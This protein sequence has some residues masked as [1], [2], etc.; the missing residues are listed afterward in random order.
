MDIMEIACIAGGVVAFLCGI[1]DMSKKNTITSAIKETAKLE[2]SERVG[3]LD[4]FKLKNN[5]NSAKDILDGFKREEER[6]ITSAFNS[7]P[8]AKEAL[9]ELNKLDK[10][11]EAAKK[12]V[13]N[14]KPSTV[15]VGAGT[16]NSAVA[17]SISNESDKVALEQKL[18]EVTADRAVA[19]ANVNNIRKDIS[20][21][22]IEERPYEYQQAVD[23]FK[24]AKSEYDNAVTANA[25]TVDSY[26]DDED[27]VDSEYKKFFRSV[28]TEG[29]IVGKACLYSILPIAAL[30]IIWRKAFFG[31]RILKEVCV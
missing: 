27:W 17:V 18:T 23:N 31:L 2:A 11:Y 24:V 28:H 1:D 20:S 5:M 26:L 12:A 14:F 15:K 19:K 7:D 4:E 9:K 3:W 29:E 6:K 8:E 13:D 10:E 30:V 22:I 21:K 25:K 16:G